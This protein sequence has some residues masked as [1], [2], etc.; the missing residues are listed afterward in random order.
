HRRG[1][2]D[3]RGLRRRPD[4]QRTGEPEHQGDEPRAD[5]HGRQREGRDPED[6]EHPPPA[7]LAVRLRR[8]TCRGLARRRLARQRWGDGLGTGQRRHEVL[9]L[10]LLALAALA[11]GLLACLALAGFTL[12]ALAFSLL[13][14]L[15]LGG[16]P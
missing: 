8:R 14:G 4:P 10:G 13:A 7:T 15:A 1:R 11:F 12:Q 3:R 6:R 9:R 2:D 5:P 16:L